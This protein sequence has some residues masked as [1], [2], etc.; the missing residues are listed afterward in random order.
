MSNLSILFFEDGELML[1]FFLE[2]AVLDFRDEAFEGVFEG[3]S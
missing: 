2:P 1:A 3:T